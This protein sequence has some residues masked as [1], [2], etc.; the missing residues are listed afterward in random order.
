MIETYQKQF[1]IFMENSYN[2]GGLLMNNNGENTCLYHESPKLQ[3]LA[4]VPG[5]INAVG[6]SLADILAYIQDT[7][8]QNV[9][10]CLFKIITAC[11]SKMSLAKY[12]NGHHFQV[13]YIWH[14]III[15]AKYI[16]ISKQD[17]IA[18]VFSGGT[19]FNRDL[20]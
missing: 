18:A 11:N 20:R 12:L 5:L 16:P 10:S 19:N 14:R 7:S 2:H 4:S 8:S 3:S 17:L 13:T 1:L 9:N 15:S 6:A